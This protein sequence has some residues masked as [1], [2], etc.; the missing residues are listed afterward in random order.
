MERKNNMENIQKKLIIIL[1]ATAIL[2]VTSFYLYCQQNVT[3]PM[4]EKTLVQPEESPKEEK[5]AVVVYVSGAVNRP[6][7]FSL[8]AGSRLVEA[9][10]NAGGFAPGADVNKVNLAMLLKDEMQIQVPF[11]PLPSVGTA[12]NGS[13]NS[14]AARGG[15]RA[16]NAVDKGTGY[17]GDNGSATG[18]TVVININSADKTELDKLPGIGPAL[19]ERIIEYRSVNGPFRE[20]TDL[21]KVSGIGEAKYK[22]LKGK[23]SL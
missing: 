3:A 23:I 11:L 20:L 2:L 6:G 10:N 12:G 18:S 16:G 1:T 9:V 19:A 15:N 17:V 4:P 14:I 8:P 22:Q 7:V 21:K 5:A 13:D